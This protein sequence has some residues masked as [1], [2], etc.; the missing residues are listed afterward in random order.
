MRV[1][2]I[3]DETYKK[4]IEYAVTKCNMFSLNQR[5]NQFKLVKEK[6]TNICNII[7][8]D[9]IFNEDTIFNNYSEDLVNDII[10]KYKDDKKIYEVEKNDVINIINKYN[11]KIDNLEE[12]IKESILFVI[13]Y[14]IEMFMYSK[15]DEVFNN[16]YKKYKIKNCNYGDMENGVTTYFFELNDESKS[17][18]FSKKNIYDWIPPFSL[19]DLCLY[20]DG[21]MWLY[22]IAHEDICDIV[23]ENEE[24]YEF[25]K[26][27]GIEFWQDKYIPENNDF[28]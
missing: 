7:F 28:M 11:F 3:P 14:S 19:E 18:L 24:E 4:I 13:K 5:N 10:K 1:K 9:S 16:T 12:H 25:L 8:S 15:T 2:N 21:F 20:K 23:C 6:F 17:I 26:S 27:I 22:S